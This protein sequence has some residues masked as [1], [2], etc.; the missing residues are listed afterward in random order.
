MKF[1]IAAIAMLMMTAAAHAQIKVGDKITM[2][3]TSLTGEKID[4]AEYRGKLVAVDFWATWC[5][6]CMAYAPHLVELNQKYHDKGLQILGISMD[7]TAA[8]AAKTAKNH[9]FTWPIDCDG[10]TFDGP[11]AKDLAVDGLPQMF[12][13]SPDGVLIWS[14]QSAD[15]EAQLTD[16]FAKH[17]PT[18]T[19]AGKNTASSAMTVRAK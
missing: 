5:G 9:G 17:P 10:L 1:W 8:T 14:G 2:Q 12:L 6:P 16:A 19:G 7:D 13:I 11:I 15:F 18:K 4:L 3:F